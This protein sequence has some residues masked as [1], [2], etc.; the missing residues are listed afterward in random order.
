VLGLGLATAGNFLSNPGFEE[1]LAVGW[2]SYIVSTSD[3]IKRGTGYEP[4]P[5]YEA[6][7]YKYSGGY[8]KL[9]QTLD[10]SSVDSFSFSIK[11]KLYAYDN[12]ADAYCWGGAAV[13][14]AYLNSSGTQLGATRVCRFTTPCPWSNTSTLH[15]IPAADTLWHT[16][17]FNLRTEL[18]NLPGVVPSQVKKVTVA[19]F[20]SCAHTC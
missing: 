1:D 18:A 17:S 4:D 16:Y 2:Q 10:I 9:W 12:N 14:I 7:V 8:T 5:D 13:I 19:L 15:L 20:D 3:T 11:A 6:Y